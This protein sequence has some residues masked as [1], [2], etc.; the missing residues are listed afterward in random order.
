MT[1]AR[2][3]LAAS[4]RRIRAPGAMAW[5]HSTSIEISMA[6]ALF[7]LGYVVFPPLSLTFLKQP[8]AVVQAG[9]PYRWLK[10]ARSASIVGASNGATTATFSPEPAVEP[11]GKP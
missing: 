4:T 1:S 10:T 9:S 8:L 7:G 2:R 3:S 5:T 11:V 6:H